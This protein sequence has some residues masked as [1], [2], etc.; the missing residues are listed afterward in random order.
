MK[1]MVSTI[2]LLACRGLPFRV[3]SQR[4]G[5]CR[6]GNYLGLLELIADYD[7]LL[8]SHI[9]K[10]GNKGRGNT[11]CLSSTICDQFIDILATEVR[12]LILQD[13]R[14]S[15]YFSLIVD[16]TLDASYV[17]QL[18]IVSRYVEEKGDVVEIFLTFL[19]NVGLKGK[20]MVLEFLNDCA[21][22]ILD[23]RGQAYDNAKNMSGTYQGHSS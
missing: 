23:C 4:L 13:I 8:K 10:Y 3:K 17:D 7:P 18:T 1:Q 20:D 11:S 6:N 22:T 9:E 14:R 12:N 15:K 19:D 21:I 5:D 16:S 2:R